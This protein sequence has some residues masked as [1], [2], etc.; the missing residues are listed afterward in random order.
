MSREWELS[1]QSADGIAYP[2]DRRVCDEC[3]E[4]FDRRSAALGSNL[5][6]RCKRYHDEGRRR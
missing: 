1:K 4:T 2:E 3:N 5:C 6:P